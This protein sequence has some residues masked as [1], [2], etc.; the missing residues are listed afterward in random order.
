MKEIWK[1]IPNYKG[2]YQASNFGKIR[3][4]DRKVLYSSGRTVNHKGMI[5]TPYLTRNGYLQIELNNRRK[6]RYL[7]HRLVWAA[8]NGDIPSKLEV[9]HK[10]TNKENNKLSNLEC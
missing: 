7:V 1:D 10:D 8:F 3:S 4:L 5:L 2:I 6:R 9:N